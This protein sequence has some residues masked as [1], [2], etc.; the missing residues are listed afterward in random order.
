MRV[1]GDNSSS[2]SADNLSELASSESLLDRVARYM[3]KLDGLGMVIVKSNHEIGVR[4]AGFA[5]IARIHYLVVRIMRCEL[6]VGS[7]IADLGC[8]L[9]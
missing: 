7:Q 4:L 2:G 1:K 5:V 8:S 6:V 3:K 9:S